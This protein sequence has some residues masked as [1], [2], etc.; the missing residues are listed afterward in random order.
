MEKKSVIKSALIYLKDQSVDIRVRMMFFLEYASLGAGLIGTACMSLLHQTLESMIPNFILLFISFLAL[1]ISH[2]KKNHSLSALI[3]IIGCANMA[4]PWMF[5]AA[6]GNN[7]GMHIWFLFGVVV[8]CMLSDGKTRITMTSLTIAEDLACICIGN[9]LPETV[10]PLVGENA[11]FYD[12]LQS[13]AAVCICLTV[14]LAIYIT[15]YEKQR[16]KLEKQSM[17]LKNIL[18]TDTLTG[19]FNRHAYYSEISSYKEDGHLPEDLVLVAMDLNGLKMINDMSGHSAGDDYIRAAAK[20]LHQAFG[21][22]GHIFRIGGD[23]FTA[24]L[25]C[26]ADETQNFE[27]RLNEC[28]AAPDNIWTDRMSVALGIVCCEE[29]TNLNFEEMEKL[30]DQRMYENKA[31]YYRKS[32]IERRK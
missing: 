12:Q 18:Q 26:T 19:M 32:G 30:A 1:F 23:E 20:A 3:M 28:I 27:S 11:E 14:M 29:N 15:T 17:E 24:L 10:K 13:Y 7:S 21:Q 31:A 22:Y 2:V 25:R 6:G 8:T 16:L 9:F 5:F 4:L